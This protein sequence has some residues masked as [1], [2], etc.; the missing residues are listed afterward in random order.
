[1]IDVKLKNYLNKIKKL[2]IKLT[3]IKF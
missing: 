3:K 2:F 1:M